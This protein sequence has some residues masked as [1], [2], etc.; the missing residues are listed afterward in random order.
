MQQCPATDKVTRERWLEAQEWER[1][2]WVRTQQHRARYCKNVAWRLLAAAGLVSKYRGEDW[3]RWWRRQFD[4]YRFLPAAVENAIEAGCG[5]Y[6]NVCLMLKRCHIRHLVLSDPLIRTYVRFK[7]TFVAEMYR[8]A[9]CV[10]DD[11]ALEA[12]PFAPGYFDLAV[13]INVLD[14]VE[15][16]RC[17]MENL[18]RIVR[19]G[20][21]LVLGQ[22]LT[23]EQDL[24]ADSQGPGDTGHPIQLNHEWFEPFLQGFQPLLK[25]V[26]SRAEGRNPDHHYGT[27]IFAGRKA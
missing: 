12:L 2:Y 26:L 10:L 25:K 18:V 8:Q 27:L 24:A 7:L 5:P 4:D 21:L 19:P 17:C 16:A 9:A 20:G 13:M 23:N 22:D 14:H 11:H 6:T 1:H 15:D 3:N